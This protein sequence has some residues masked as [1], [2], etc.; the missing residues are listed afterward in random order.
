[1]KSPIVKI[2]KKVCP[3]V[4]TIVASKDLPKIDD[5]YFLPFQGEKVAFPKSVNNEK[6]RRRLGVLGFYCFQRWICFNL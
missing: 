6:Q 1:M 5:F 4:V 3:A 2:A